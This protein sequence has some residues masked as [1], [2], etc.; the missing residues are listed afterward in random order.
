[1]YFYV[2]MPEV[3]QCIGQIWEHGPG[4]P[5]LLQQMWSAL[6]GFQRIELVCFL[7][8]IWLLQLTSQV[9]F[10]SIILSAYRLLW[11]KRTKL[12]LKFLT[13]CLILRRRQSKLCALYTRGSEQALTLVS[14][15]YVSPEA[16][17]MH[18]DISCTNHTHA[19]R[20]HAHTHWCSHALTCPYV[21]MH[22][23]FTDAQI[24]TRWSAAL[25]LTCPPLFTL[26]YGPSLIR[27]KSY[28][29][30][31]KGEVQRKMNFTYVLGFV[32]LRDVVKV[33]PVSSSSFAI[34]K[35]GRNRARSYSGARRGLKTKWDL[36][37]SLPSP[38]Y[39]IRYLFI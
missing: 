22:H 23:S 14:G 33:F 20:T 36:K 25:L 37:L 34:K 1:M 4:I 2:G 30:T 18:T 31:V 6:I 13:R 3:Q 16:K 9:L 17:H 32:V 24:Y 12:F 29:N 35:T 28:N 19:A 15:S 38:T 11:R 5:K 39:L 21:P 10:H 27:P 8:C 26:Y 7:A